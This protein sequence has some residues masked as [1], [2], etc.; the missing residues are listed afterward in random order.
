MTLYSLTSQSLSLLPA[1][2]APLLSELSFP[3]RHLPSALVSPIDQVLSAL[4]DA[5]VAEM[6]PS[7]LHGCRS[8]DI[9]SREGHAML[10]VNLPAVLGD[11][12]EPFLEDVV[13]VVLE[14][15]AD[16]VEP[17]SPWHAG[18]GESLLLLLFWGGIWLP[19]V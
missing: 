6:M 3:M 17:V 9:C 16:E 8:D 13:P 14:G 10:W 15:L 2:Q 19:C 4:G 7:L 5:K 1:R 18:V 12:F 11:R